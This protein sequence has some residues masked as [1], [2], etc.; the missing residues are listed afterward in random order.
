MNENDNADREIERLR[1][2]V[3]RVRAASDAVIERTERE[4]SAEVAKAQ[5]KARTAEIRATDLAAR[6][7][8]AANT[9]RCME[10]QCAT[11]REEIERLH[12][13]LAAAKK[14]TDAIGERL[15]TVTATR[16]HMARQIDAL[17]DECARLAGEA[18]RL[19]ANVAI[20]SVDK[21]DP[22]AEG[23]AF[24]AV[25]AN[26]ADLASFGAPRNWTPPAAD[27]P[28]E[29][30]KMPPQTVPRADIGV[31]PAGLSVQIIDVASGKVTATLTG[32]AAHYALE[33]EANRPRRRCDVSGHL[34]QVAGSARCVSCHAPVRFDAATEACPRCRRNG[35]S[36]CPP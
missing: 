10:E 9:K 6:L 28:C 18:G 17:K 34:I 29:E 33:I 36:R 26:A 2:E 1:A 23:L 19:R 7:N 32:D 15:E 21:V 24:Y 11:L 13:E 27:Y 30:K 31:S 22:V 16:R 5:D 8:Y 3:D 35:L 25:K 12:A 20:L 4:T 14:A